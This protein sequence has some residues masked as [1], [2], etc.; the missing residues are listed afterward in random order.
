MHAFIA[1]GQKIA[2]H[3]RVFMSSL[4]ILA[5]IVYDWHHYLLV[6]QRE[7]AALFNGAP[8]N[9]RPDSFKH[10]Q[11]ILLQR[12]RGD[13]KMFEV[14]SLILHHDEADVV[15]AVEMTLDLGCPS[16]Q[17]VMNCLNRLLNPSPPATFPII[18][19]LQLI[20]QRTSDT[21]RYDTLRG[22]RYAH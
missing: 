12:E 11:S 7:P 20:T 5:Q 2:E 19:D 1:Q 22:K 15:K 14:I 9:T 4:D 16:K 6:A 18:N 17:H 3:N 13:M 10:L 8:F 21:T